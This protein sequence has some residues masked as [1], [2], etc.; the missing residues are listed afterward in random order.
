MYDTP[1]RRLRFSTV[2]V[3]A[4]TNVRYRSPA[5]GVPKHKRND[6]VTNWPAKGVHACPEAFT[7]VYRRLPVIA[8]A[9]EL[10]HLTRPRTTTPSEFEQRAQFL[11]VRRTRLPKGLGQEAAPDPLRGRHGEGHSPAAL[12]RGHPQGS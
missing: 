1:R 4:A 6:C 11:A 9:P 5:D 12:G 2:P 8:C 7:I 3:Y 10:A